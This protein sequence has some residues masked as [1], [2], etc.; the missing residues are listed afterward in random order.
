MREEDDTVC[1]E[2]FSDG[3]FS[4]AITLRALE[5]KVPSHETVAMRGLTHSL[6]AQWPSS[7]ALFTSFVTILVIWAHFCCHSVQKWAGSSTPLSWRPF[8]CYAVGQS[9]AANAPPKF[10]EPHGSF[11]LE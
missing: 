2:A 10:P 11:A 7:L 4:I 5:L 6:A 8:L 9:E 3:G 1:I